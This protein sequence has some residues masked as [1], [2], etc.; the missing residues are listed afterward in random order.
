MVRCASR[1]G[2]MDVGGW[3]RKQ[4]EVAFRENEIDDTVLPRLAAE[5]LRDLG[6]GNVGHRRKLFLRN[7][8]TSS[9]MFRWTPR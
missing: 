6:V 8:P 3:L 2:T 1:G 7:I 4:Y 5:D 9:S